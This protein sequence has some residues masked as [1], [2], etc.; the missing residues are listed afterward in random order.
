MWRARS[1]GIL[2]S[3]ELIRAGDLRDPSPD[4]VRAIASLPIPEGEPDS[5]DHGEKQRVE[6]ARI[7]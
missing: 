4:P 6:K 2:A 1:S 7:S 3:S 5:V